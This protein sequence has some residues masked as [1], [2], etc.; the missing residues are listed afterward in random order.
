MILAVQLLTDPA[1]RE[2]EAEVVIERGDHL[3]ARR[4][5]G[6]ELSAVTEDGDGEQEDPPVYPSRYA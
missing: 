1:R 2:G 3:S 5:A 6:G 4:R